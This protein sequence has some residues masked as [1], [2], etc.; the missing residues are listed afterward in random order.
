MSL[1]A[2]LRTTIASRFLPDR[3]ADLSNDADLFM[4]LDS[5]DVIRLVSQLEKS[6]RVEVADS[7][8][9]ADNLSSINRIAAFIDRKRGS[10]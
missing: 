8:M 2:E 10:A 6:Y 9:T 4:L 5:L 7:E 1:A 3:A